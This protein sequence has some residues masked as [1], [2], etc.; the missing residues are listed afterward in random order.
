[1]SATAG[2]GRVHVEI[3]GKGEGRGQEVVVEVVDGREGVVTGGAEGMASHCEGSE[4]GGGGDY[5]RR[6]EKGHGVAVDVER[7]E[8]L[9]KISSG[10]MA[11]VKE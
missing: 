1:M 8:A 7:S 2:R 4:G 5:E 11:G 10:G 9:G 6:T 3:G